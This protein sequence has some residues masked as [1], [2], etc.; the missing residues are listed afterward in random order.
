MEGRSKTL[1]PIGRATR[2]VRE[3]GAELWRLS[4]AD[5]SG[6]PWLL[7]MGERGV[8]GFVESGQDAHGTW[9]VRRLR[10]E[11]LATWLQ[12]LER[13]Q[14]WQ[15]TAK[16]MQRLAALLAVGEQCGQFP[17]AIHPHNVLFVA[18]DGTVELP[19]DDWVGSC[20]GAPAVAHGKSHSLSSR[21]MAPEHAAGRTPDFASNRYV[22]GLFMYRLLA[23]E[24]PFDGLG[25]RLALEQ[26]QRGAPPMREA[27]AM[28]LPPGLQSF[29][30]QLLEPDPAARPASAQEIAQR[31]GEMLV[32]RRTDAGLRTMFV[33]AS[34]T[35]PIPPGM[36]TAT[37]VAVPKASTTTA[38]PMQRPARAS[39][40]RSASVWPRRLASFAVL[41][42][43]LVVGTAVARTILAG[44]APAPAV[45]TTSDEVP[46]GVSVPARPALDAAHTTAADC[47]SCHPTQ[48]AQWHRSVM[49]HSAK[50]PLFQALE[51]LIQEQVGKGDDC[52]H[53]AGIL[54]EAD[55]S[56]ACVDEGSRLPITG[57][58]GALWCVN[59]HVPTEN[60]AESL[61]A[62]DGKSASSESRRPLRDQ[63]GAAKMEGISCAF[64]HQVQGPVQPGNL[65]RGQYEGNPTWTSTRTGEKIFMR[66]ED[67][68]GTPGIANSGYFLDAS[69]LLL[70]GAAGSDAVPGGAHRRTNAE[71]KKYLR[72]SE[73]CGS[74]HDVRLFGADAIR[75]KEGERFKRLRNAYTEWVRYGERERT[76]GREPASCQDCHMSLFPAVCEPGTAEPI[77]GATA[78]A[79]ACP[80]GTHAAA[81]A[82]GSYPEASVTVGGA[83]QAG[84]T[85]HYFSGVDVPLTPEFDAAFID[86]STLD[87]AGVPLGARQRRDLLLGKTF[88]FEV[89]AVR[90]AAQLEIPVIIENIGAGHRVP[91]GFSQEREFWVHLVVKD[92]KDAIVY[93]VGRIERGDEDLH[94]KSFDRVNVSDAV[95]D[96]EGRPLGLFGADVSDGVDVPLWEPDPV[97]GGS[98][99]R[100]K[101]LVNLQNGFLRCVRCIGEIDDEGRCRAKLFANS[102]RAERYADAFFDIDT[103]FCA[104]NLKDGHE[105]LETYFPIGSLDAERGVAKGPD[106]II[107]TRS[108]APGQPLRYI[109]ELDV[110]N[111]PGPLKI[112]ARLMFRAFPPFLVRAFADYEARQ[113]ELGLRPSGPLVT[114]AMLE[115]LE[116]VELHRVEVVAK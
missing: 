104:S 5:S 12:T 52:P 103:G 95:R 55:A 11:P 17:G 93:E 57:S 78:L 65:G 47:A 54:R 84:L 115:R 71:A 50:S 110:G 28:S 89:S 45:T 53:G 88:R 36:A 24:H 79:R 73:F 102:H 109:Y 92:A 60:L 4:A 33:E 3:D 30:L 7:W 2:V 82:P 32:E 38:A 74:C 26:A 56:T 69:V 75:G 15:L 63:F 108:A 70:G 87:A 97:R 59:C 22:L 106:A 98:E 94:D 101:G 49:G 105:F 85:T 68:G 6:V 116:A 40:P 9:L 72:S 25:L 21:W 18:A 61:P 41:A 27:I 90:K 66:P 107:D 91:A 35:T 8:G 37:N 20:V 44:F 80:P 19:A 13:P 81:R 62:W 67:L 16:M 64:C 46:T 114:H 42:V 58:G 51:I 96:E 111:R 76:L 86:Q 34:S 83:A 43:P 39:A 99:F 48:T 113:A 23:D 10:G 14:P 1:E 29:C 112:E 77:P 100:G 31:L